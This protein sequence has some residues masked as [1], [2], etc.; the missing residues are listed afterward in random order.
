[1]EERK[2][3]FS[4]QGVNLDAEGIERGSDYLLKTYT[5]LDVVGIDTY[6]FSPAYPDGWKEREEIPF[7]HPDL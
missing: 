4:Q 6:D 5:S 2:L 1:M 3:I 7:W